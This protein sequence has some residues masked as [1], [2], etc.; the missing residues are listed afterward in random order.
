MVNLKIILIISLLVSNYAFAQYQCKDFLLLDGMEPLKSIGMDTTKNWWAI[1]EPFAGLSRITI[2]GKQSQTYNSVSNPVFSHD[3]NRW[4]Y[5]AD[6]NVSLILVTNDTTISLGFGKPGKIIF[7]GNSEKLI[8]SYYQNNT[9]FM[10]L[11]DKKFEIMNGTRDIFVDYYG[12]SVA[13]VIRKGYNSYVV[14]NY[15]EYG[16][17]DNIIIMGF[18]NNGKI[19]YAALS[20]NGWQFYKDDKAI[21]D[22]YDNVTEVKANIEGTVFAAIVR[23]TT[24]KYQAILISDEYYE[25]LVGMQY[26][27]ASGLAL[28]PTVSLYSYLAERN[29]V[30]YIVFNS[31]EYAVGQSIGNPKFSWDGEDLYY[32]TCDIDCYIGVN[33]KRNLLNNTIDV[34]ANIAVAPN[35]NTYA[36]STSSSLVVARFDAKGLTAGMMVDYTIPPRFNRFENRYETLGVINNKLYMMTCRPR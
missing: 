24:G 13:F 6:D 20:G 1:T 12:S 19:V 23:N 28:H 4:A 15:T 17:Y 16:I 35:T 25:P 3:G 9:E 34:S 21:S 14:K 33:G 36:Y 32:L 11:D 29:L 8:Y 7:S 26:D 27:A 31:A 30:K 5:F 10:Y 22:I 2:S 18:D